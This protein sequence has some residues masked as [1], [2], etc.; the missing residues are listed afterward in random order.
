M[1]KKI[2]LNLFLASCAGLTVGILYLILG[3]TMGVYIAK[4]SVILEKIGLFLEFTIGIPHMIT[5]YLF[6]I[7]GVTS[8]IYMYHVAAISLIFYSFIGFIIYYIY[9]NLKKF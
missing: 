9:Y 7:V 8:D 2:K 5:I 6:N 4:G 3:F 1:D